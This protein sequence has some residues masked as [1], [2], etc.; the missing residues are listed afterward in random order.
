[1][2]TAFFALRFTK[3]ADHAEIALAVIDSVL[4]LR[5]IL[6]SLRGLNVDRATGVK[7]VKYLSDLHCT[8]QGVQV[9]M[10]AAS[11]RYQRIM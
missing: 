1:M 8:R 6:D 7:V 5:T 10:A 4:T 3:E 11:S 2:L 9:S